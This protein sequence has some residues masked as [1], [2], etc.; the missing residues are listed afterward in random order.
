MLKERRQASLRA[1]QRCSRR[2]MTRSPSF[3][4]ISL[5]K[6]TKLRRAF[7]FVWAQQNYDQRLAQCRGARRKF[8]STTD[9]LTFVS[10]MVFNS[11]F[12]CFFLSLSL[13]LSLSPFSFFFSLSLFRQ[14]FRM[15]MQRSPGMCLNYARNQ[16][17]RLVDRRPKRHA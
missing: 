6:A 16:E 12:C 8:V 9:L 17:K 15:K 4:A 13:F 2:P 10:S 3:T 5:G 1:D 11:L 7:A 14:A